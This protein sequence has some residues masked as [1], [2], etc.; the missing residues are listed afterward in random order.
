MQVRRGQSIAA[1]KRPE[2]V[3]IVGRIAERE[4]DLSDDQIVELVARLLACPEDEALLV[5]ARLRYAVQ[6]YRQRPR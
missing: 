4:P 3:E 5:G 6:M 2:L 1:Y